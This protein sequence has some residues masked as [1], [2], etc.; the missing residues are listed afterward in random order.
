V[1]K[2]FERHSI[3]AITPNFSDMTQDLIPTS[4]KRA[5]FLSRELSQGPIF[6]IT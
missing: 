2:Y 4:P 3:I 1:A 6:A 5:D